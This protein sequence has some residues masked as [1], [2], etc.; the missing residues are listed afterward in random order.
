MIFH[1]ANKFIP[2]LM[3]PF[4]I[5]CQF[6]VFGCLIEFDITQNMQKFSFL[7]AMSMMSGV[8]ITEI[9]SYLFGKPSKKHQTGMDMNDID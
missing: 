3:I 6:C 2:L 9:Y 1:S 4:G 8:L 5:L 7:L